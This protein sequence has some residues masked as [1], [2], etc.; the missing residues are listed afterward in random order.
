MNYGE[1]KNTWNEMACNL[2]GRSDFE[3]RLKHA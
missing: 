2:K 1:Y 3:E